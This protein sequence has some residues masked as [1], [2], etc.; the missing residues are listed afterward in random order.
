MQFRREGRR[1][2]EVSA[3]GSDQPVEP[4]ESVTQIDALPLIDEESAQVEE[5]AEAELFTD[6][7]DQD[8]D[9]FGHE[10]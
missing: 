1:W 2:V 8:S 7:V 3:A 9:V 5:L 4:V 10:D 6:A